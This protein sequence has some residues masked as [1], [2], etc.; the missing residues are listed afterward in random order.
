MDISIQSSCHSLVTENRV[1]HVKDGSRI[2]QTVGDA[3]I[4]LAPVIFFFYSSTQFFFVFGNLMYF[5][6]H[7]FMAE[8]K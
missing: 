2:E 5:I 7:S 6:F 8:V 1:H 3:S 4:S